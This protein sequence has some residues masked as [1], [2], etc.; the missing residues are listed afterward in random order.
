MFG[1]L[2]PFTLKKSIAIKKEEKKNAKNH[3]LALPRFQKIDFVC[4][5]DAHRSRI[6][7]HS[8]SAI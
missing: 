5:P 6:K 7:F 8:F 2:R 3:T 1:V 4:F